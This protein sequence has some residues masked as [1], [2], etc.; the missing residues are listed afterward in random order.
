MWSNVNLICL[1][2]IADLFEPFSP[3]R[4]MV[5]E[6]Q[7]INVVIRTRSFLINPSNFQEILVYKNGTRTQRLRA[8]NGT[9]SLIVQMAELAD[10]GNYTFV[11][12]TETDHES[13]ILEIQG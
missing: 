9:A 4:L 1:L 3:S 6:G 13:D 10:S 11:I 5:T 8:S 7:R 12:H 2:Y